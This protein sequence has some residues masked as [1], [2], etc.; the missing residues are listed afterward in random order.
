MRRIR[1]DSDLRSEQVAQDGQPLSRLACRPL[2]GRSP[3]RDT[4]HETTAAGAGGRPAAS[5]KARL[6]GGVPRA[7]SIPDLRRSPGH[8]GPCALEFHAERPLLLAAS[9][10]KA[11]DVHLVAHAGERRE[12]CGTWAAGPAQMVHCAP[13]RLTCAEWCPWAPEA[14]AAGDVD[15]VLHRVDI[16]SAH[17]LAEVDEHHGYRLCAVRH[18]RLRRNV[19]ASAGEDGGVRLW[20]GARAEARLEVLGGARRICSLAFSETHADLLVA[21][22]A[23]GRVCVWDLR[24]PAH[25]TQQWQAHRRPCCHVALSCQGEIVSAAIDGTL[26]VWH[27]PDGPDA[28]PKC[29]RAL[30]GQAA[31]AIYVRG[32]VS[33]SVR[34]DGAV[35][36][37]GEGGR[38]HVFGHGPG[39]QE[40]SSHQVST[41]ACVSAVAWGLAPGG[42][43]SLLATSCASDGLS[44][45][46]TVRLHVA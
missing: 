38:A 17:V 32:S 8:A 29:A 46:C 1:S 9:A 6:T 45:E 23:S 18:S 30:H 16:E 26:R 10:R 2:A 44:T 34:G 4:A 42:R 43:E 12:E 39:G 28:L 41:G 15:G 22:D 5:P 11:V 24:S 31:G 35:A 20:G 33:V 14:I 40:A 19:I 36:A 21:G 37:G 13:A 25:P 27:A 3:L 7:A